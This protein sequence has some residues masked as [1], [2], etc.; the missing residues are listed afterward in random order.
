[1]ILYR[2]FYDAIK[3]LPDGIQLEIFRAIFDYGLDGIEPELSQQALPFWLLIK[4]NLQ[5][6]R[7]KWESGCK[8]KGKQS[9]SKTEAKGKQKA[10]KTE[11]RP[12]QEVSRSEANVD[13]YVDVDV[14]EDEEEDV[15]VSLALP[16]EVQTKKFIKPTIEE[17]SLYVQSKQPMA[18]KEL[19]LEFAEKFHSFYESNGWRVG[20]NPMK[21]WRAA[22]STWKETLIKTLNPFKESSAKESFPL[23]VKKGSFHDRQAEYLKGLES[24]L[25]DTSL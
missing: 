16:S 3:L 25:T 11:A 12:K 7:T 5:A 9:T 8:A 21:N 14:E 1:M 19:I 15:N 10:S 24:I 13:V 4:P 6:N 18:D 22:I 23:P 2:S 17:I 20:K